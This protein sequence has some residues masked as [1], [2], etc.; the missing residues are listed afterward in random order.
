MNAICPREPSDLDTV[1]DAAGALSITEYDFFRLAFRR[2]SGRE[3]EDKALERFFVDYMFHQ[4]IPHWVRHLAR[5]VNA[6]LVEGRLD[7]AEIG[8]LDYRHRPPLPRHGRR[9]VGLVVAA[10]VIYSV[11]LMGVTYDPE[12]SAP[13]PC[14][15]GPGFKFISEMAYAV[16]GKRPPSC[17][18]VKER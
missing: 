15:G 17:E 1:I 13:M 8:A 5:D 16:T 18:T 14:Y 11:A 7:L 10:T 6:R 3:P 9:C 12:T 2:W 4:T